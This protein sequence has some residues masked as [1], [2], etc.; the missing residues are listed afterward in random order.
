VNWVLDADMRGFFDAIDQGWLVKFLEHRIADKRVLR[1]IQK[2]LT[3][4]VIEDGV[5]T[6]SD[7]GTP[8]GASVSTLLANVYLHYVFDLWAHRWRRR[9]A[10]GDVVIVR[11]ADDC[12][13][14]TLKEDRCRRS[15]H[16]MRCCTGDGGWPSA[17]ALQG[18]AANHRELRRSRAAVVSVAETARRV[19]APGEN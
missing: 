19:S 12:V 8:Q 3:A 7:E 10:C 5:K 18:E 11:Y 15:M 17:V 9:R 1:L 16:R 6:V 4:G 2:W 14:R 13:P